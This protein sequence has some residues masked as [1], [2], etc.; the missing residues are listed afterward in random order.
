MLIKRLFDFVAALCGLTLLAPLFVLIACKIKLDSK[1][2]IFFR[3][4]RVG[5]HGMSFYIYKFRTMTVNTESQGQLTV[6]RDTRITN[7]GHVL[8]H[9]KLDELPQLINV[10]M[11]DMSIVGP[12]PEVPR[13]VAK[14]PESAKSIILS[15]RPGI[16]DFASIEFKDENAIL[17][18]ADDPEFEYINN[19]LPK[20]L[21]YYQKY[22][23]ER[24]F[25]LDCSLILK[26]IRAIY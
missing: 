6:G 18:Q 5:R 14:Y 24:S 21:F 13:Y 7:I 25:W 11:G 20:K 10:L 15:V 2:P 4:E 16:T 9:Y 17:A 3:Q 22:V 19:V 1:G 12:R 26:T 23:S 8:R